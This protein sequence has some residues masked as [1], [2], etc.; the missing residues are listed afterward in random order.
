MMR[1]KIIFFINCSTETLTSDVQTEQAKQVM[2]DKSDQSQSPHA[3]SARKT[4]V[5]R[6]KDKDLEFIRNI[7]GDYLSEHDINYEA[8]IEEIKTRF[9][10]DF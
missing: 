3:E 7:L 10:A 1:N 2:E 9:V 6:I 8:L 4:C 5:R